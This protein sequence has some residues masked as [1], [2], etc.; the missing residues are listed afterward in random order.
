MIRVKTRVRR[1]RSIR[2]ISSR[3]NVSEKPPSGG[4]RRSGTVATAAGLGC[5]RA[6]GGRGLLGPA[7]GAARSARGGRGGRGGGAGGSA[8]AG[9]DRG[10]P[11]GRRPPPPG[12]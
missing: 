1:L 4:T 10:H 6:G 5:F 12:G 7:G 11:A 3:R 8:S 2:M 9:G